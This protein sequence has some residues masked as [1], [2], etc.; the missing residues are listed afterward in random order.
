MRV[1]V[2]NGILKQLR[3]FI[4]YP[5]SCG[6]FL[7]V[8]AEPGIAVARDP[9]GVYLHPVPVQNTPDRHL[10]HGVIIISISCRIRGVSGFL[11]QPVL[12]VSEHIGTGR[13]RPAVSPVIRGKRIRA[14]FG[15]L[16]P[17]HAVDRIPVCC[18]VFFQI[19]PVIPVVSGIIRDA[20]ANRP[21]SRC[22]PAYARQLRPGG[23]IPHF[24]KF[25]FLRRYFRSFLFRDSSGLLSVG[26]RFCLLHFCFRSGYCSGLRSA[27]VL[28]ILSGSFSS[29]RTFQILTG[30]LLSDCALFPGHL[31]RIHLLFPIFIG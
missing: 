14:V 3:G 19:A 13:F 18:R 1:C 26:E 8:D 9:P 16:Y 28:R 17:F 11:S 7:I 27:F 5:M 6:Q 2:S 10:R 12:A 21:V 22:Y 4:L 25:R 15:T 30:S 31:L 20:H 29:G 23:R 24:H